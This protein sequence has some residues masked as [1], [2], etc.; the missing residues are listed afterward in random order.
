MRIGGSGMPGVV[1]HLGTWP[2]GTGAKRDG[3]LHSCLG[4][5]TFHHAWQSKLWLW[6]HAASCRPF[7]KRPLAFSLSSFPAGSPTAKS[8][9]LQTSDGGASVVSIC[10]EASFKSTALRI[11]NPANVAHSGRDPGNVGI[12]AQSWIGRRW[13]CCLVFV[14]TSATEERTGLSQ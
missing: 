6:R 12:V 13:S 1:W 5:P 9:G 11:H 8:L 2:A 14:R 3:G 10:T 7:I 4:W